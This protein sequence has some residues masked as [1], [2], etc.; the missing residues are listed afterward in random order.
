MGNNVIRIGVTVAVPST[1]G[2]RDFLATAVSDVLNVFEQGDRHLRIVQEPE[3]IPAITM[4][5]LTDEHLPQRCRIWLPVIAAR[6]HRPAG[7]VSADTVWGFDG[8]PA[9]IAISPRLGNMSVVLEGRP[10]GGS[11]DD[12]T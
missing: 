10:N 7:G 12:E 3:L 6:G 11:C 1:S 8:V 5:L 4:V 9:D 2:K